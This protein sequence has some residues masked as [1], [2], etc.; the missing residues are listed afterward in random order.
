MKCL[1]HL[2]SLLV[3]SFEL[4]FSHDRLITCAASEL[5]LKLFKKQNKTIKDDGTAGL[6]LAASFQVLFC[7][8]DVLH[9]KFR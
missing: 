9:R 2:S 1:Q 5:P 8:S 7:T 4:I 6:H 3:P